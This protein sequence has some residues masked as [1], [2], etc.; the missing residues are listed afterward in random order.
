MAHVLDLVERERVVMLQ[1]RRRRERAPAART[2]S[3]THPG[4]WDTS[5]LRLL[6]SGGSILSGDVK[7]AAAGRAPV[8]ARDRRRHRLVG[9]AGAGGRGHDPRRRRRRRRCTSRPRPTTIVVDDDAAPR[10]RRGRGIVGRLATTRPR[11]AR[12]LQGPG[13]KRAHV[14]R[15]RRRALVAARRH[16]DDRRRRHRSTCSGAARCASTPAAR[17]CTPRRSRPC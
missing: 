14:R 15:D 2:R 8:G 12:L 10:S 17:R 3:T 5:S 13:A 1:P 16:G 11:P 9:V 7:D 4:A 6:G